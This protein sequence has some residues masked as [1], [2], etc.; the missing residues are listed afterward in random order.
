MKKCSCKKFPAYMIIILSI[1][2]FLLFSCSPQ[3]KITAFVKIY[4]GPQPDNDG[5]NKFDVFSV[6][7]DSNSEPVIQNTHLIINDIEMDCILGSI[8]YEDNRLKSGF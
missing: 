8:N 7:V 1:A 2:V 6:L 4:A 3:K 5:F